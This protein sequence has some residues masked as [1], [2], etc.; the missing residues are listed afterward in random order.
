MTKNHNNGIHY[1]RGAGTKEIKLFAGG[2]LQE[3]LQNYLT[4]QTILEGIS[5]QQES[6]ILLHE[7]VHKS[8]ELIHS[9]PVA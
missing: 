4:G 5:Q 3:D 1:K 8:L 6:Y 9:L 7:K 2:R